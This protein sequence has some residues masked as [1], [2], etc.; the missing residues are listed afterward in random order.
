MNPLYIDPTKIGDKPPRLVNNPEFISQALWWRVVDESGARFNW[1][2]CHERLKPQPNKASRWVADI[3]HQAIDGYYLNDDKEKIIDLKL[4]KDVLN[5][6]NKDIRTW[7]VVRSNVSQALIVSGHG[8]LR[9]Y[10]H[11]MRLYLAANK[12][13]DAP[14]HI[15]ILV[16]DKNF[17][18]LRGYI[19]TRID[20]II[21]KICRNDVSQPIKTLLQPK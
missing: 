21:Y 6:I 13:I 19:E 5:E 11:V 4:H 1:S 14:E 3:L 8:E 20:E 18:E 17:T 15:A 2:H 12:R 9:D 7:E 16:D 10:L